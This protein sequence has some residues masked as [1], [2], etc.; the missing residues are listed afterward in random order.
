MTIQ[1]SPSAS[2]CF[3]AL[4]Y[5]NPPQNAS[6]L[7]QLPS[8]A[9]RRGYA[10]VAEFIATDKEL[11]VYHRFDRTA[12][13]ILLILQSEILHKQKQLDKIDA[14]DA[15]DKDEKRLLFSGTIQEEFP[16]PPDARDLRK[17]QLY[18]ELKSLLKEY[19]RLDEREI[20]VDAVIGIS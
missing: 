20:V 15:I 8:I 11:A 17:G 14:E 7:H 5:Y 9:G 1:L 2:E 13:R 10:Q 18:G 3:M 16:G 4:P 19:C 12:A 6:V